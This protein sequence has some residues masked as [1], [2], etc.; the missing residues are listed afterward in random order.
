MPKAKK[1]PSGNWRVLLY[2]G[3]DE[4][5][6]RIYKSFTDKDKRKALNDATTYL[7]SRKDANN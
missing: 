6:K 3:K 2:I 7:V 5:G 1:L 4:T